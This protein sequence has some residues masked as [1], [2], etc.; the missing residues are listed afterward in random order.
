MRASDTRSVL[1]RLQET[2]NERPQPRF[3]LVIPTLKRLDEVRRLLVS[4]RDSTCRDFEVIVVDQNRSDLLDG[5]CREFGAVFP[6]TH[7]KPDLTG[8]ARARNHG[9]RFAKGNLI[10]FPDDD[11]YFTPGLLEEVSRRFQTS[12]D[13]DAICGRVID[14]VSHHDAV[15]R[16]ADRSQWV[17]AGNVY[18]TTLEFTMFMKRS[19]LEDVG[20]LDEDLGVGT[21]YGAEEGAD[22]V[23]RALYQG[24]RF[25]YDPSLVIY[26]AHKI[27]RYDAEESQK[28]FNYGRGFGRMSVK[29]L[30]LYRK[31]SALF[32]FLNFQARAL[33]AVILY[34]L[35][36]KP[37]RS[38]YYLKRIMGRL[39]GAYQSYPEFC[40]TKNKP[41]RA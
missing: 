23:L 6:L 36:L 30:I 21:Y 20:P 40:G 14:P 3:S 10:N 28:T 17:R 11:C 1:C 34:A 35:T 12:P 16:F 4:L 18:Q 25:Y 19:V 24:K 41:S 8:A 38:R 15:L 39:V 37:E 13:L 31:P 7:L 33:C 26:H 29:H 27:A 9:F 2:M 5:L 22:F 32:R